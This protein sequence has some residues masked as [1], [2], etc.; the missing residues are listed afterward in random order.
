[1]EIPFNFTA[2]ASGERKMEFLLYKLPDNNPYKTQELWMR[3]T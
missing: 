1:M 2:G 3:I